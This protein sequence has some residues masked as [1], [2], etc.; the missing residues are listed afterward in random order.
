ME[1]RRPA[2]IFLFLTIAVATISVGLIGVSS[3]A[4]AR[5]QSAAKS[6][7][8]TVGTTFK[9]IQV[10][11]DLKDQPPAQLYNAMQFMAGSL[12]VS[13]NYCHVSEHGPFD[14]DAKKTKQTAREMIKMTRAIN[15]NSFGGQQ[16]VTCNTCHQGSTHPNAVPSPWY[17]TAEQIAQYN[18]TA[19]ANSTGST[20]APA[21]AAPATENTAAS[22]PNVD[23]IME[24][25]R[26][27]VGAAGLKSLNLK[28][29][30]LVAVSGGFTPVPFEADF[31]FPDQ[32]AFSQGAK[33]AESKL[34]VN[35]ERG[36]RG[37]SQSFT[38]LPAAQLAV[39]RYRIQELAP[40]KDETPGAPAK[41]AGME[42]IGGK[43]YYVV[44]STLPAGLHQLFFDVQSGLLYKSRME[45]TT[46]LGK[47]VEEQTFEDY[48]NVNGVM[49]SFLITNHYMEEQSVYRISSAET[50]VAFAPAM[51]T[52]V[53]EGKSK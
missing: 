39:L 48:R 36:W 2:L 16:V 41:V 42:S 26:Q 37:N 50:N 33:G 31:L 28:G 20:S 21:Q 47:K 19:A 38:P 35:G 1:R 51:F 23:Q 8:P 44:E 52:P 10:L 34:I 32:I 9:N 13:C 29:A 4:R 15:A 18:Q 40:V 7:Q 6:T 53:S 24:R 27:A 5:I 45:E 49:L 17:K 3:A 14:S 25:Y 46:V 12:S 43:N 22:L 11:I 30:N